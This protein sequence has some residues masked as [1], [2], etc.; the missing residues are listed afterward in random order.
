MFKRSMFTLLSL[1]VFSTMLYAG[2]ADS[3]STRRDMSSQLKPGAT[4]YNFRV[5]SS[6][7]ILNQT[8]V[9]ELGSPNFNWK[10]LYLADN[11]IVTSTGILRV[12]QLFLDL[13][14]KDDDVIYNGNTQVLTLSTLKT[15]GTTYVASDL[16]QPS[17][18]RNI[19]VFASITV[20]GIS[21]T[22]ATV[23]GTCYIR[24]LD[25]LGRST[26]T[27]QTLVTTANAAAGIGDI[28]WSYI[29]SMTIVVT[30]TGANTSPGNAVDIQVGTHDGI[31][32]S[33][34]IDSTSDIYHVVEAG[35]VTTSYTANAVYGTIN[36][37][38]A[39][40]GSNDYNVRYV[41]KYFTP[42]P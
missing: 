27:Y 39:G 16:T 2:N 4:T 23:T 41:Q 7:H 29:S 35:T 21:Q 36:F 33:N 34:K 26:Y 13:P 5:S 40:N 31:G 22:S 42:L 1:F 37:A 9:G 3:E 38:T 8:N 6:G 30:S 19:V 25:A 14:A 10:K 24:G 12:H 28:A 20:G 18:P 15:G 32:L 11:G 17:V